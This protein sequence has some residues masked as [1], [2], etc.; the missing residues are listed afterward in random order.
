MN[1]IEVTA[2]TPLLPPAPAGAFRMRSREELESGPT[3]PRRS[4]TAADVQAAVARLCEELQREA[5][6]EDA[7]PAWDTI[8]LGTDHSAID[9][10]RYAS[11]SSVRYQR[12]ELTATVQA[13]TR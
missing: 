5:D 10:P 1:I 2:R 4:S 6:R 13:V 3:T 12:A 8:V 9:A 7:Q 11:V